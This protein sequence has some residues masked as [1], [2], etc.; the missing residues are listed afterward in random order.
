MEHWEQQS[1]KEQWNVRN[2]TIIFTEKKN[3][4]G[5]CSVKNNEV[6]KYSKML[7]ATRPREQQ[8]VKNCINCTFLPYAQDN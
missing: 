8:D 6:K 4:K 2:T 1:C 5:Q 3:C 7:K